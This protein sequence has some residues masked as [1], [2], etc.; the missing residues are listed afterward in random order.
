M[1]ASHSMAEALYK[2]AGGPGAAGGPQQQP[3][4]G[5][6]TG[7]KEEPKR[8]EGGTGAVD[9]DYEVVD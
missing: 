3:G 6:T 1:K 8:K 2:N 5:P 4:A 9:A 7:T